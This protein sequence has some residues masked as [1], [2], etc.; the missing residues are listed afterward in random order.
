MWTMFLS[1]AWTNI[2]VVLTISLHAARNDPGPFMDHVPASRYYSTA[3]I[4]LC[5]LLNSQPYFYINVKTAASLY[6]LNVH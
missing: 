5:S 1:A 4:I 6:S 2:V 3:R